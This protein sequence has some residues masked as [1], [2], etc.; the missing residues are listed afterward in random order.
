MLFAKGH[1]FEPRY[2]AVDSFDDIDSWLAACTTQMIGAP[3]CITLPQTSL[4]YGID[5][6]CVVLMI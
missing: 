6:E 1:M 4:A 5:S 3:T 2:L